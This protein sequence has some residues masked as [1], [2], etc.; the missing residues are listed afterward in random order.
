MKRVNVKYLLACFI[1]LVSLFLGTSCV[2]PEI[3]ILP[4]PSPAPSPPA[5]P[6]ITPID[7]DFSLPAINGNAA[8]L[9]DIAEMVATVKPSVVAIN[10]KVPG[11]NVFTGSFTQEG[12]GSG[13]IVD[14]D[15]LI[16]TNNH[17]V[18]GAENIDVTLDDG[19]TFPAEAVRT[20]HLTDLAV[21]KINA[22]N[23]PEANIGDSSQ[24]RV[25]EWVVVIGNSLGMGIGATTG[26]ISGLGISIPVSAGQTLYD[27]MQTDAA[28]N[29][30]NSGGPLVNM[31]GEVVGITSVK[32]AE[33]GVEGMGY[34]MSIH[35]V[36]PIIEELVRTGYVVRPWLGVEGLFT[37]DESV[38]AYFR[39]GVD[40][41]VLVRGVTPDSPAVEA[42]LEPGDVIIALEDEEMTN[43]EE[44][45]QAVHAFQIGQEVKITFWRGDT[46]SI[47]YVTLAESP[48][49]F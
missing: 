33:V 15:G 30:G 14:E 8:V 29:P 17:V 35:T 4:S 24:L 49:P 12:A 1:I 43:V 10:T 5:P 25:G 36:A 9:P 42:G 22:S 2:L 41:G 7:P 47:T 27:L 6:T 48:P 32:I 16:V 13:W 18:Q 34:A 37:V 45:R 3:E 38:A 11:Y 26:I 39:L 21:V 19:R 31:A 23:L 20:D 44:L 28:I 46:Q 40:K